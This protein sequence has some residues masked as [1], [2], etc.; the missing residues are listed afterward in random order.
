ML[1]KIKKQFYLKIKNKHIIK[2]FGI[3]IKILF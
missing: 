3:Y 2:K 1:K